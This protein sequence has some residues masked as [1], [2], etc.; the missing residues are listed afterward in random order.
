MAGIPEKHN[1][2][3]DI[4]LRSRMA[5]AMFDQFFRKKLSHEGFVIEESDGTYVVG[6]GQPVPPSTTPGDFSGRTGPGGT[7]RGETVRPV[8]RE[9]LAAHFLGQQNIKG[10]DKA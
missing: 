5:E 3:P 1:P 8:S 6:S 4:T 9:V 2:K 10:K 7:E